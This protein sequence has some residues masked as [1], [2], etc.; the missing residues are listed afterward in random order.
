MPGIPGPVHDEREGLLAFL[1][2]QRDGIRN[3]VHGLT[4]EQAAQRSTVSELTL[5]GLLKHAATCERGW[6]DTMLQREPA[7][8]PEIEGDPRFY[9]AE[10]ET[11][12]SMLA[13]Y[14]DVA[15]ETEEIVASIDLDLPVPVPQGVPW[16]PSDVEAWSA[17]WVLLHVIE[18]TARHAG[19]ADIIR[20]AIDGETAYALM[21]K[22][23]Q[24]E[25]VP[26]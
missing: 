9:V 25:T 7:A 14:D 11:L 26:W 18:E 6:M 15:R 24:W 1:R 16:F 8:T 23:E 10:G 12:E 4:D 3:A 17:R 21:A 20:D 19:H 2:Q 13:D 22:A 5:R